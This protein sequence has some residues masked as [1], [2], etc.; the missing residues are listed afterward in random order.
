[1]EISLSF[2]PFF[3][4]LFFSFLPFFSFFFFLLISDTL[5]GIGEST[6]FAETFSL[7]FAYIPFAC[8][9]LGSR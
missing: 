6:L 5:D 4:F 1:M 2:L 8:M 3:L 9:A 7:L